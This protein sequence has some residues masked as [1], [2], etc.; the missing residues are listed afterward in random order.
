MLLRIPA[1]SSG[2]EDVVA[3]WAAGGSGELSYLLTSRRREPR[4]TLDAMQRNRLQPDWRAETS[5][6]LA[7]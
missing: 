5:N 1:R 4:A 7:P 3:I 6:M 2:A